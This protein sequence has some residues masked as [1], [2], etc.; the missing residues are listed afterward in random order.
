MTHTGQHLYL[1][2]AGSGYTLRFIGRTV[3]GKDFAAVSSDAF[4]V[5][6]GSP[7]KLQF[8]NYTGNA[9]GG[10]KFSN[11][12][13]VGVV[14]RGGNVVVTSTGA[15]TVSLVSSPTGAEKLRTESMPSM[16]FTVPIMSGL[17]IF[18]GLYINE[19][20]FPYQLGFSC[21]QVSQPPISTAYLDLILCPAVR[22]SCVN[23]FK[24]ISRS[25]W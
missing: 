3:G 6:V 19:A 9:F 4:T 21:S 16:P 24:L 13:T 1:K 2:R 11:N 5:K 8:Y 18:R 23:S 10:E 17:A 14:D 15:V 20:G 7:Y 22:R 12:P 25:H